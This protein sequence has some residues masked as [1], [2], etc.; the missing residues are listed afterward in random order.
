[1][2]LVA[3]DPLARLHAR[4]HLPR[5]AEL[6]RRPEQ[7]HRPREHL[8]GPLEIDFFV[9]DNPIPTGHLDHYELRVEFGLGRVKNLLDTTQ[10]GAFTL[11]PL[12][13]GAQVGPDYSDAVTAAQGGAR[14]RW[15]GGS[16]RLHI[17]DASKAS[18]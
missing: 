11:T 16:M 9:T 3:L 2:A 18:P 1:M 13:S 12:S 6:R 5:D 15:D 17:D 10:V 7:G 4:H 14:P 8:P